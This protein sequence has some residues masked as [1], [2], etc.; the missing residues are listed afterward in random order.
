MT[1]GGDGGSNREIVRVIIKL[2][3]IGCGCGRYVPV[4]L[5]VVDGDKSERSLAHG[6]GGLVVV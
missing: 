5:M 2:I 3:F 4:A 6:G 1:G